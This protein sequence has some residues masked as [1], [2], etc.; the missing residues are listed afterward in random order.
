M[1]Y[2]TFDNVLAL[3][4]PLSTM[5]GTGDYQV[6]T[7]EVASV[8]VWHAEAYIDAYL[9]KR[10]VVPLSGTNP[11]ITQIASDLAIFNCLAEKLP[12]VPEFID[13][14]KRRCDSL[15]EKLAEGSLVLVGETE[16]TSAGENYA[17]SP[18]VGVDPIFTRSPPG[19]S[20]CDWRDDANV[21]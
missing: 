1:A 11:L 2:A 9:G 18:N 7:S 21:I 12:T 4:P 5:V 3:Y 16:V 20:S 8:Y 17:Y 6:T 14:R 19:V 13:K 10:Y 15:L